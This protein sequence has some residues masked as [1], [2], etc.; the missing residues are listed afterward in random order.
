[1]PEALPRLGAVHR[2]GLGQLLRDRLQRPG[3]DQ[4]HVRVAQPQLHQDDR[5]P[6]RPRLA[7][8]VDVQPEQPVDQT[9]VGVEHVPPDQQHR[10]RRHGVRQDQQRSGR[11]L[12]AAHPRRVQRQRAAEAEHE[13]DRRSSRSRRRSSRRRVPRNGPEM[14]GSVSTRVKLLNPT[15]TFQPWASRSPSAATKAPVVVVGRPDPC[16]SS[17][18][19]TQSQ[20]ASYARIGL[21]LV[22]PGQA[23]GSDRARRR[24][25]RPSVG[26]LLAARA[27]LADVQH[28]VAVGRGDLAGRRRR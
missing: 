14:A 20:P 28:R 10:E 3:G 8:P 2:G 21:A 4:E 27:G 26:D 24:S 15:P 25:A 22:G 23:R 7:E 18:S 1:M 11:A 12:R 16:R 6:G 19:V 13:G 5:Q 17:L 9:E